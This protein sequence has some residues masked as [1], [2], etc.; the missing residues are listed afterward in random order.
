MTL[1][2]SRTETTRHFR[3]F[4]DGYDEE[5]TQGLQADKA[6]IESGSAT[7]GARRSGEKGGRQVVMGPAKDRKNKKL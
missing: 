4:I 7:C 6:K 1:D 3:V 2:P 5:S